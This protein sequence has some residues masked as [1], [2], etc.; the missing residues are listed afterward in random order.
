M[1]KPI[2]MVLK[3]KANLELNSMPVNTTNCHALKLSPHLA[4]NFTV[5]N[6]AFRVENVLNYFLR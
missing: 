5:I 3:A 4:T 6:F 1:C 2:H